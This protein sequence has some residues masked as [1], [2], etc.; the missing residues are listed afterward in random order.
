MVDADE[1]DNTPSPE[2]ALLA[3]EE[4]VGATEEAAED[5]DGV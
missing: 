2:N 5:D 1:E 3:I 4:G